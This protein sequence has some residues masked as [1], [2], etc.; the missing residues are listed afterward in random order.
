MD[1]QQLLQQ[2]VKEGSQAAFST[3]VQ[4]HINVVYAAALRQVREPHLAEDVTQAVFIVLHRK[5]HKLRAMPTLGG[6]L[7]KV[8]RFAA[9]DAMRQQALQHRHEHAAA[10]REAAEDDPT[11]EDWKRVA[12]LLDEAM[13][14]LSD[15]DRNAI[16]MRYME[17]ATF[18]E[19][20]QK[21]GLSEDAARKRVGRAMMKLRGLLA[22][23][24][25]AISL[26]GLTAMILSQNAIAAPPNL[27]ASIASGTATGAAGAIATGTI[28]M[29]GMAKAKLAAGI[30]GALLLAGASVVAV[31]M[32]VAPSHSA[33][34]PALVPAQNVTAVALT[35][36]LLGPWHTYIDTTSSEPLPPRMSVVFSLEQIFVTEQWGTE[37]AQSQVL[38]YK[39]DPQRQPM[40][41]EI[42]DEDEP[43]AAEGHVELQ[44]NMLRVTLSAKRPPGVAA[45]EAEVE[46]EPMTVLLHRGEPIRPDYVCRS[47]GDE[48][49]AEIL[50]QNESAHD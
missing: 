9:I 38:S 6:W 29:M 48:P 19:V 46:S 27:V 43:F 16:V 26:G 41:I 23:K 14:R 49:P 20:G 5:A 36:A 34:P 39:L 4:R 25:V 11:A 28:S 18:P 31:V 15:V 17:D 1:D 13:A 24:G 22:R 44:S 45:S 42:V 8:T 21:L 10:K 47:A 37:H 35:E 3:L 33:P 30:A 2:F 32:Q 40:Y 50:K 12:P 7:L